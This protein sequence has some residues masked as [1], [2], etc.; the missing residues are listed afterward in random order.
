M[1]KRSEKKDDVVKSL[2]DT[3]YVVVKN[4]AERK[5]KKSLVKIVGGNPK[6]LYRSFKNFLK[7]NYDIDVCQ[8]P[9]LSPLGSFDDDE[10]LVELRKG[11][12]FSSKLLTLGHEVGHVLTLKPR[13]REKTREILAEAFACIVILCLGFKIKDYT[14]FDDYGPCTTTLLK[15]EA[16]LKK[17]SR[18]FLGWAL[19]NELD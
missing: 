4:E 19:E 14:Y 8:D 10:C 11:Q 2:V 18:E 6:K 16:D 9:T 12:N 3:F 15:N 7:E 17:A 1:K 5:H 13:Q